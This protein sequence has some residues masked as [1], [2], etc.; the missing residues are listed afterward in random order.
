MSD[1]NNP[2][3]TSNNNPV[4]SGIHTQVHGAQ[5][6]SSALEM[7]N[8]AI[9]A[10]D[11]ALQD[12]NSPTRTSQPAVGN[13]YSSMISDQVVQTRPVGLTELQKNSKRI[14]LQQAKLKLDDA[15]RILQ[16]LVEG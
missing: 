13:N 11:I 16:G 6:A 7:A 4:L 1:F 5:G 3:F 15:K 10:V 12:L 9:A 8:D 14:A 2:R